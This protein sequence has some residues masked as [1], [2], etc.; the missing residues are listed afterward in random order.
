MFKSTIISM[1]LLGALLAW[2]P[3][4]GGEEELER[5]LDEFLAG[6]SVNDA[7]IHDRFWAEDL[8]YTSSDGQ[9][10]GKDQIM[11]GL[12]EADGAEEAEEADSMDYSARDTRIR[13]FDDT[14]VVTF[15][16][17]GKTKSQ[18]PRR[19]YNTGVFRQHDGKW[20]A[21]AWQAT[22]VAHNGE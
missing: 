22:R 16:L 4:Q 11:Q 7:Q 13:V 20:Q 5:L 8:V 14:A 21:V 9:R 2:T 18:P 10:F 15:E 12:A 6:A 19:F 17:V 1:A 3:A